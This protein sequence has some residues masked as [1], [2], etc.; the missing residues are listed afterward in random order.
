MIDFHPVNQVEPI[1][2][3]GCGGIFFILMKKTLVS[4]LILILCFTFCGCSSNLIPFKDHRA[5]AVTARK[6]KVYVCG[7]IRREGY[8]EV[9]EGADYNTVISLAGAIQQTVFPTN[10]FILI[11]VDGE[12]LNLQYY[13][14]G[15][16]R[17]CINLNGGYIQMRWDVEGIDADVI[18]RIADYYDAH[19]KITNKEILKEILGED[20]QDNYYKFY[21]DKDDY[22]E[23]S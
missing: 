11:K 20:Y 10:S 13:D 3:S 15:L 7:A 9:D 6:F 19:G 14:G 18:N 2:K 17:D 21:V 12:V 23:I 1:V 8:V 4:I 5:E 16:F 22:E